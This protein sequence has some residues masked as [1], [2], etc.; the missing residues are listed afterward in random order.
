MTSTLLPI[1]ATRQE[2][3]LEGA[4]ARVSDVPVL[5]RESWNPDT[6][7]SA[8]LP[9]LAWAF[10]VDQWD[11]TWTDDQ[12]RGAIN[13]SVN[14]HRHKGT[15][16]ALKT[17]LDAIGYEIN[18]QEWHKVTP[19][20]APYTFGLDVVIDQIGIAGQDTFDQIVNVAESAKNVR[21]QLTGVRILAKT[22]ASLF[23]GGVVISGETLSINTGV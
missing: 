3:A 18:L 17:A 21:S 20:A 19:V 12:K 4:T 2:I 16:G 13:A 14:V 7:P 8:L 1:S 10:S 15:P 11:P 9:W 5:V 23:Y 6:C 22:A